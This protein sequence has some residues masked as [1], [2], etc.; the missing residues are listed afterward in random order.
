MRFW[1]EN[2]KN[3][4]EQQQRQY[5]LSLRPAASLGPWAELQG[6]GLTFGHA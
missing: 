3:K 1:R 2:A 5:N 6:F 4:N